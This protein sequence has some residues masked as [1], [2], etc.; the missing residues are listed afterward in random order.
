MVTNAGY[1]EEFNLL[2]RGFSSKSTIPEG[3]E[4]TIGRRLYRIKEGITIEFLN[5]TG[6]YAGIYASTS[7]GNKRSMGVKGP[8][9]STKE[10]LEKLTEELLKKLIF[11]HQNL[12]T[13]RG[14]LTEDEKIDKT[15][16]EQIL[17]IN[18]APR[19]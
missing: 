19:S 17:E 6:A 14:D 9:Y 15:A 1:E 7:L 11:T 10:E 13:Q 16:L 18:K 12:L 8:P 2:P 5:W 3:K 4:I